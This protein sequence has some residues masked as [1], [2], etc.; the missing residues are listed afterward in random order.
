[1]SVQLVSNAWLDGETAKIRSKPVPWEGYQRA[2]LVTPEELVLIK[3]VDRQPRAKAESIL[4]SDGP[5]YAS[6]YLGLLKKLQRPDTMQ[7]ILILIGDA[8]ADHDERIPLFTRAGETDTELPY[9]PLLRILNTPDDFVQLKTAQILAVLLSAEAK[10][11]P[12]H[13]L[14]SFITTLVSLIQS[15]S[16]NHKDVAVQCLEA[17][18]PRPEARIAVWNTPSCISSLVGI[19]RGNPGPQMSYQVIFCFWLLT[20]EQDIAEQINK[21]YDIIPLLTEVAQ[22]A[23][24]E[25]VIRVVVSTFRNLIAKA[26]SANLPSMLVAQLLPFMKNLSTRKWSDEDILE[27]VQFL[28]DELKSRFDS[29]TNYDEYTSELASGHLSWTPVHESEVFWKENA[30]KLNEKDYEQLKTLVRLLKE[31]SDALVLAVA[32]HDL[33]QYVKHYERG[34]KVV[35]DLG[36]KTRVM[37]LM[38]HPNPDVRYQALI[39]V[40]R[41]VSQPWV[42][43]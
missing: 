9:G 38:T 4:L 23:V 28:R 16:N 27:D 7:C 15:G 17:L 29:L 30:T 22:T 35:T 34:K 14:H 25:K 1:M 32:A 33:G 11:L 10:P 20:F 21:K 13:I 12:S 40:Q 37:E 18:L 2:G 41:L 5:T 39:S 19:L 8:L 42:S 24:K 6:L 43:V 26:P 3:K 31:S 36:A